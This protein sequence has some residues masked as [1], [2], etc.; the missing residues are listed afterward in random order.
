MAAL[1]FPK[2]N[3]FKE[4]LIDAEHKFSRVLFPP[5]SDPDYPGA[6]GLAALLQQVMLEQGLHARGVLDRVALPQEPTNGN[7]QQLLDWARE[8]QTAR[9][10]DEPYQGATKPEH[11][12]NFRQLASGLQMP[13][14][15]D[16]SAQ[17]RSGGAAAFAGSPTEPNVSNND[18]RPYP[19]GT[20]G[21]QP[22]IIPVAGRG[23][24]IPLPGIGIPLPPGRQVAIPSE[25]V[26]K[27]P[28]HLKHLWTLMQVLPQLSLGSWAT[29]DQDYCYNRWEQ[30]RARCSKFWGIDENRWFQACEKRAD[31][32]LRLCYRNKG[33]PDP[34]EPEEYDLEG[35]S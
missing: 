24:P 8:A 2:A 31:D 23:I 32:R 35:H 4:R 15:R 1:E 12:P 33:K 28:E 18:N 29:G 11:D 3:L 17:S 10:A 19:S 30:D 9:S 16:Q 5:A 26:P 34:E 25:L 6:G 14:G 20:Y 22:D 21:L 7:S 27:V 13:S